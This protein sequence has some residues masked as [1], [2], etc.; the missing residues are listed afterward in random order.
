MPDPFALEAPVLGVQLLLADAAEV[1]DGKIFVLGGGLTVIGPRPQPLAVVIRIEVP[2]D[3]ANIAHR[4]HLELVDEDGAPVTVGERPVG[5]RGRFEAGRPA[6][7]RPGTPLSVPVA[8]NFPTLPVTGGRS[9]TWQLAI[10]GVT[11]DTW[12]QSFYVRPA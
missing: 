6:G 10:D 5:V 11:H 12:R 8:V 4:W 7:L 9:Y 1:A 3:R 2:W